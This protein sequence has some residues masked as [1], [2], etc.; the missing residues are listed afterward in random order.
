MTPV[1][2]AAVVLLIPLGAAV[3]PLA[4]G[5]SVTERTGSAGTGG[6]AGAIDAADDRPATCPALGCDPNCGE[7]GVALDENGCPTCQC[8]PAPDAS[9]CTCPDLPDPLPVRTGP[10]ACASFNCSRLYCPAGE[11]VT[12]SCWNGEWHTDHQWDT[13][14]PPDAGAD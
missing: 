10:C 1:F 9:D 3:A 6:A 4:C 8:N 2:R 11:R 12:L 13:A 14:C 7:A 5:G